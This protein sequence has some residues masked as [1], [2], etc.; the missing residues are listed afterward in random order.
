MFGATTSS[1][2]SAALRKTDDLV[3]DVL[4]IPVGCLNETAEIIWDEE[5]GSWLSVADDGG[6][7]RYSYLG[8]IGKLSVVS[9]WCVE[10]GIK[11]SVG[12]VSYLTRKRLRP[13]C[14]CLP[15]KEGQN[16]VEASYAERKYQ[17][18]FHV[19]EGG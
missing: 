1:K 7:C 14:F 17:T 6:K 2:R 5:F 18:E 4:S 15:L 19:T 16:S 10:R 9:A 8:I 11:F 12:R 13:E 3:F